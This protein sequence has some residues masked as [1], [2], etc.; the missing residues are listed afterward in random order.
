MNR[1]T[2]S[3]PALVVALAC[4]GGS[5][6]YAHSPIVKEPGLSSRG[7]A[8]AS[9]FT[10]KATAAGI[11][12]VELS[13]VAAQR[14]SSEAVRKFAQIMVDDH[15]RT[16][17]A[18]ATL[19]RRKHL[20]VASAPEP[21]QKKNADEVLQANGDDFDRA[22]VEL[23]VQEHRQAVDLFE[24]AAQQK[25]LDNDL[26]YFAEKTTATLRHHQESAEELQAQITVMGAQSRR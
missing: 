22:Y 15:K 16:N 7:V 6:V 11:A 17:E 1:T 23:M 20:P 4:F 3:L 19:A 8:D 18:L 9:A 13:R 14:A 10:Q 21:Q 25:A 5:P 2:P 12:E 24:R 26:R